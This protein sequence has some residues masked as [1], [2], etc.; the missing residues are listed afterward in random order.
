MAAIESGEFDYESSLLKR[1]A[2][3]LEQELSDPRSL[4]S[5]PCKKMI[6]HTF[7][8]AQEAMKKEAQALE[9]SSGIFSRDLDSSQAMAI[10]EAITARSDCSSKALNLI[11]LFV[12]NLITVE[13][14]ET[15]IQ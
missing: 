7:D 13:E 9:K 12:N 1:V 2:M 4:I 3:Q 10:I 11:E 6:M 5:E 8:Y 14:L 15:A